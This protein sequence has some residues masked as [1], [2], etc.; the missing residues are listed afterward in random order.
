MVKKKRK[1]GTMG[2][3]V[4]RKEEGREEEDSE[5][6]KIGKKFTHVGVKR[7]INKTT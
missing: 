1:S 2:G 3:Q 6:T 5:E 4:S 7:E